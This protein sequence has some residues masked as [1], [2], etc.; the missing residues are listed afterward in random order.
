[1]TCAEGLHI[2][3]GKLF[4]MGVENGVFFNSRFAALLAFVVDDVDFMLFEFRSQ[5]PALIS[6]LVPDFSFQS[7]VKSH[8]S[9]CSMEKSYSSLP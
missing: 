9:E 8:V 7:I 5:T 3:S 1:M 6:V 2:F 4:R